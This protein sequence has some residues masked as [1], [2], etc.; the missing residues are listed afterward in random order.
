MSNRLR[1]LFFP[2]L[3]FIVTSTFAQQNS[4]VPT[5]RSKTEVVLVPVLVRSKSGP[6]EGLKAEQFSVTED[7]KPQK[8]VSA[9]LIKTGTDVKRLQTPGEFSNE[10]VAPG[11]ARLTIVG[12]PQPSARPSKLHR[13]D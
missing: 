10:L 11:P 13:A 9:E 2:L 7:G 3:L 5:Y 12:I 4:Q 1:V 8:I 6:V